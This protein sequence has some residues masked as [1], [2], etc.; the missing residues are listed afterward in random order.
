[1]TEDL[2]RPDVPAPVAVVRDFV[3]TTDHETGIDDLTT[4]AGSDRYLRAR[5]C[6]APGPRASQADLALALRLRAGLRAAL[7]LNHAGATGAL[8]DLAERAGRAAGRAGWSGDGV[9]L[10]GAADGVAGALAR[11]GWRPTT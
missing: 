1:M 8:P 9:R 7:E 3:N 10:V 4:P 11:S 5:D 2:A 6:S